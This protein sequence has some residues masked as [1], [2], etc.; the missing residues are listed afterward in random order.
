MFYETLDNVVL[1]RTGNLG[2]WNNRGQKECMGSVTFTTVDPA[3]A[4]YN[5][6]IRSF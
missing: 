3:D 6:T 2:V 5:D 4:Q 1:D